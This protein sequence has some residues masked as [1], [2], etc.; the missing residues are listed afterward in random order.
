MSDGIFIM[1]AIIGMLIAIWGAI[2]LP[3]N[4]DGMSRSLRDV[5]LGSRIRRYIKD[6]FLK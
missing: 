4:A 5:Y 1:I 6:K 3:R 2:K